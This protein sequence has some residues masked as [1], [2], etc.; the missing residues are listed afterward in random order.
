MSSVFSN[1]M[2]LKNEGQ[3]FALA[4]GIALFEE[5]DSDALAGTFLYWI[6]DLTF[7]G[8]SVKGYA[9][10]M[11]RVFLTPGFPELVL[12]VGGRVPTLVEVM[13][14][15]SATFHGISSVYIPHLDIFSGTIG[16]YDDNAIYQF[17]DDGTK[18][19]PWTAYEVLD[20]GDPYKQ[21]FSSGWSGVAVMNWVEVDEVAEATGIDSSLLTLETFDTL[22]EA[23]HTEAKEKLVD[24]QN[25]YD[26]SI[27]S[28]Y[29]AG[30]AIVPTL[31]WV[32]GVTF[33]LKKIIL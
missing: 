31:C 24:A 29:S 11:M 8:N 33:F 16:T 12:D 3:G 15:V 19:S 30:H 20:H 2:T 10:R 17:W 26:E 14:N 25:E 22:Y 27:V 4:D 1:Y 32:T 18:S 5:P 23:L 21:S 28:E 7:F 9:G 6:S 13:N